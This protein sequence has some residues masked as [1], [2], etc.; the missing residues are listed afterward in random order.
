MT[1]R[2]ISIPAGSW[3]SDAQHR[4]MK[5]IET[6]L[7]SISTALGGLTETTNGLVQSSGSNALQIVAVEQAHS[8]AFLIEF[9]DD[10][11]YTFV[12]WGYAWTIDRVVTKCTAGT[13]TVVVSIDGVNLGGPANSVSTGEDTQAHTSANNVVVGQDITITISSNAAA[14]GVAVTL[15]GRRSLAL[16]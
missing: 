15:V 5:T 11:D 1:L 4:V 8:E 2:P 14:E 3:T 13:C 6:Q 16:R 12:S 7:N 10:K 9:A